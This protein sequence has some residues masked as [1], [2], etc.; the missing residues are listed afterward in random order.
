MYSNGRS[1]LKTAGCI[2]IIV[3]GQLS[4]LGSTEE[5]KADQAQT[6]K[7]VPNKCVAL[8]KGRKCFA[9]IKV[10]WRAPIGDEYCLRRLSDKLEINCWSAVEQGAFSYVFS[11]SSDEHLELVRTKDNLVLA[12]SKIKVS[13]V[14]NS[15]KRRT[16]WR[17]F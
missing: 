15:N 4:L 17:V 10:K 5:I 9:T 11:S 16:R 7:L 8:R 14:Y 2:C 1:L 6:L 13:W 12:V 3:A